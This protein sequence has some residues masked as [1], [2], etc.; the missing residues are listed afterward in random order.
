MRLDT[1]NSFPSD[2]SAIDLPWQMKYAD[3]ENLTSERPIYIQ[4]I[5]SLTEIEHAQISADLNAANMAFYQTNMPLVTEDSI[6]RFATQ[7]GIREYE[8]TSKKL[9]KIRCVEHNANETAGYI[10]FTNR[11]LG[12]HTDGYYH[13]VGQ[14]IR[15]FILHCNKP[16]FLGGNNYFVDHEALYRNLLQNHP[17]YIQRLCEANAMCIPENKKDGWA[18]DAVTGPVFHWD[19][20]QLFMRYTERT[21]NVIWAEGLEEPLLEIRKMLQDN[22]YVKAIRFESGM[23]VICRNVIHK[24]DAFVDNEDTHRSLFRAR[25]HDAIENQNLSRN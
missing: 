24:R 18:R 19:S 4:N 20:N 25:F 23:G 6:E 1:K 5:E 7:F 22:R 9:K 21:R 3:H 17:A 13:P 14:A 10:P 8:K 15:S 11:R 2:D 16:A 12:W